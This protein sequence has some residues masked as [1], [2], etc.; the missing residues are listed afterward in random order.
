[1]TRTLAVVLLVLAVGCSGGDDDATPTST[2]TTTETTTTAAATTTTMGPAVDLDGVEPAVEAVGEVVHATLETADGRTRTYRLYLPTQPADD[3]PL[4]LALHGGTG[5]G[6]QFARSSGYDGLAE[7]NGFVI[8]YP[9]GTPTAMGPRN[10]VWNAGGCCAAAVAQDVDDV[11]FLTRLADELA[12]E[13]GLDATRVLVVGHSNGAM[14]GLRLACEAAGHVAAVAVQAGT[15][16]L[17]ECAPSRP[18]SVLD[19]HGTADRNLPIDGG[20]GDQSLVG[21][22][23]PPPR[24]GLA[25][26]ATAA[27][28]D[29]ADD[30]TV[31]ATDEA[32]VTVESWGPCPDGVDVELVAVQGAPHAWMDDTSLLTWAFLAAHA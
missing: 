19:L 20:V 23:Y 25:T 16:F 28:C 11:G 4:V 24:D 27:G 2:T 5:N 26:L 10:L 15:V 31:R 29:G 7:A 6:D 22:D 9:D 3:A 12:E 8:A 14:M 32:D 18:V 21:A 30:P 17:D 1:M 13:H